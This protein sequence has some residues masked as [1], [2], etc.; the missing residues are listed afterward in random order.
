MDKK[1]TKLYFKNLSDK[2][3]KE[4]IKEF[5]TVSSCGF[6][7]L[8]KHDK[9]VSFHFQSESDCQKAL[10]AARAKDLCLWK[11]E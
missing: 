11:V 9:V 5:Q 8:K 2:E 4:L 1:M 6:G 7:V 10:T 3:F